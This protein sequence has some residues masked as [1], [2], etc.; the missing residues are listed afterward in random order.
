MSWVVDWVSD[1]IAVLL[2]CIGIVSLLLL[3]SVYYNVHIIAVKTSKSAD[4]SHRILSDGMSEVRSI[5][6]FTM[7]EID[8]TLKGVVSPLTSS[9]S[10]L[11]SSLKVVEGRLNIYMPSELD[12]HQ[13]IT[14]ASEVFELYRK[15]GQFAGDVVAK[16]AALASKLREAMLRTIVREAGRK[17]RVVEPK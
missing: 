7:R 15:R 11:T 10:D 13:V 5:G 17:S 8:S 14:F 2:L 6:E 1:N 4:L 16:E 9:V 12:D 3:F